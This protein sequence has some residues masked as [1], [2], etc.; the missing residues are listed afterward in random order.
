MHHDRAR[1]ARRGT[2]RRAGRLLLGLVRL[3]HGQGFAVALG[4][5]AGM[6]RAVVGVLGQARLDDALSDDGRLI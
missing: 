5:L 1:R 2:H 6:A 3:P 4:Q